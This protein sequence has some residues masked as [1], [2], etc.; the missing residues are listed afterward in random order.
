MSERG[1]TAALTAFVAGV[2]YESLPEA[3]VVAAK[4]AFVDTLGVALAGRRE[5]GSVLLLDHVAAAAGPPQASVI[6]A[7]LRVAAAQAALLNGVFG[8]ALDFDD[9][10]TVMQGHPSVVVIP[11]VLALGEHLERD[12]RSLIA[13]YA[14]GFEVACRLGRVL[15]RSGYERGWHLTAAVGSLAAAA[16][17]A[18]LLRLDAPDTAMA[19]A[20]AA[21][22]ASGTRQNFGTMT[23]PLHAGVAARN[24]VEAALLA[25]A[26]FTADP[27]AIEGP[28]GFG[29]LFSPGGDFRPEAMGPPGD[30]WEI[31][32]SGVTVKKYPCCYHAH[33]AL[34]AALQATGGEPY[35]ESAVASI[36]V[37]APAGSTSALV[38]PRPVNGLEGKFSL[39]YCLAAAVLDGAISLNTFR[40][41]Q[42]ARPEAQ[43][44][45][46]RVSLLH[47]PALPP[48]DPGTC[49]VDVRLRGGRRLHA[50]VVHERGS[51]LFPLTW[52]ELVAK[53][54]DCAGDGADEVVAAIVRL[55]HLRSARDLMGLLTMDAGGRLPGTA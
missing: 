15:G 41:D 38:H 19:L 47:Y 12:G 40:D 11:A 42:V 10:S 45:L 39:E 6:G 29:R 53:Y 36:E 4:R 27:A 3:A 54:C 22:L 31:V 8:H 23:K 18:S 44:L 51:A 34:D 35:P 55:E 7:P 52:E 14:A 26:G 1:A 21:S 24:G 13:A 43:S 48:P 50:A 30:P 49:A 33:R 9:V 5:P 46:R 20:I 17:A 2:T 28:L 37:R 32:A 25:A 16:A